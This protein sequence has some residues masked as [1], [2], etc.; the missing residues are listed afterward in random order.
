[1][2]P[3]NGYKTYNYQLRC[4]VLDWVVGATRPHIYCLGQGCQIFLGA[5]YQNGGNIYQMTTKLAN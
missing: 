2:Q 1:M 3:N 4:R 5:I